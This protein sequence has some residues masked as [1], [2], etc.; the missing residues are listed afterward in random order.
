[1]PNRAGP[2]IS[3]LLEFFATTYISRHDG[4]VGARCTTSAVLALTHPDLFTR[5]AATSSSRPAAA[6]T[7]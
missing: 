6:P 5:R 2:S 1:M 4:F 7:A 3:Q